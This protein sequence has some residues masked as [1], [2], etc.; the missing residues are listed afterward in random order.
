MCSFLLGIYP[1]VDFLDHKVNTCL[2]KT[3]LFYTCHQQY[4]VANTR[5]CQSYHFRCSDEHV[6]VSCCGFNLHSLLLSDVGHSFMYFLVFQV[7]FA[8]LCK[9]LSK[10][11]CPFLWILKTDL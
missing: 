8:F 9:V 10:D 7:S 11:F 1:E 4:M 5:Y 3:V 2:I 6:I